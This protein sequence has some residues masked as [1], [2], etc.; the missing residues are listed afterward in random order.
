MKKLVLLAFIFLFS[1]G[2]AYSQPDYE[3]IIQSAYRGNAADQFNLGFMYEKGK[4]VALDYVLVQESSRPNA[5]LNLKA[6][7]CQGL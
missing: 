7:R 3:Q 6:L 4:G 1:A 5:E 2:M